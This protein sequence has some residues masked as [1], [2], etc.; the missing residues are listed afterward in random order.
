[1]ARMPETASE[2]GLNEA[3]EKMR[4]DGA[5][6]VAVRNFRDAYERLVGGE[7]GMLP[8]SDIEPVTDIPS[9]DDL[10]EPDEQGRAALDRAIVLRLNGGMG[11]SMGLDKAK[12]LME[13][14]DGLTFLDV[15]ARQ[16]LRLRER[17]GVR[18]PLVLMNSFYTRD[19]SLEALERYPELKGDIPLDFVQ[20]R[21][22]KIT[23]DEL[24]PVEWEKDPSREWT[25][26]GHGDLY[27][28]LVTSGMLEA[29]LE[30]DY[31]YAFLSNSDNL[32]AVLDPRILAWF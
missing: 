25:P 31:E 23:A 3:L 29:L 18:L 22:P 1:M 20:G 21:I 11:T 16:V 6:D 13:V 14:K 9:L 28:S 2:Q 32:G 19:D 15:I 30:H 5:P 8:E 12:S 4:S 27:S 17:F 24:R 10:P 7:T 26:P